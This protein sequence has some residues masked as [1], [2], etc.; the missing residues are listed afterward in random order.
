MTNITVGHRTKNGCKYHMTEHALQLSVTMAGRKQH[1]T[2]SSEKDLS[3][4]STSSFASGMKKDKRQITVSTFEKWQQKY[5]KEHQ[6][7]SGFSF[8]ILVK[9]CKNEIQWITGDFTQWSDILS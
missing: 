5:D 9:G 6:T 2:Q 7:L 4:V 8:W 1:D 3:T